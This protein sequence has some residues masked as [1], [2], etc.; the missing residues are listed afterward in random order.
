M[1]SRSY[2]LTVY[3]LNSK[4]QS[5]PITIYSFTVKDAEKHTLPGTS[6]SV[7]DTR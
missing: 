7:N 3:A 1:P 5:S 6:P 2:V 4:G